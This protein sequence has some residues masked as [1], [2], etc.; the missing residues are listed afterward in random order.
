MPLTSWE[1]QDIEGWV[2]PVAHSEQVVINVG[3]NPTYFQKDYLLFIHEYI[4]QVLPSANSAQVC[5]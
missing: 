4:A 1:R 2:W 3:L 5:H